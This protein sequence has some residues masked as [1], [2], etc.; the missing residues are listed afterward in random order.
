MRTDIH[1]ITGSHLPHPLHIRVHLPDLLDT[2]RR[3]AALAPL[4]LAIS[5]E[6]EILF[7]HHGQEHFFCGSLGNNELCDADC[8]AIFEGAFREST[9]DNRP[10]I[11]SCAAGLLFFA[12]PFRNDRDQHCCL[13]AGGVRDEAPELAL[14]E[15]L[16]NAPSGDGGTLLEKLLRRPQIKRAQMEEILGKTL[17]LLTILADEQT[18]AQPLRGLTQRLATVAGASA[19]LDRAQSSDAV[20]ELLGETLILLFDL[21]RVVI[22]SVEEEDFRLK[23]DLGPT[24]RATTCACERLRELLGAHP[25]GKPLLLRQEVG[26]FFPEIDSNRAICAPL[27]SEGLDLGLAVIFDV[28]LPGRDLLLLELLTGRAAAR[29]HR[30]R[31]SALHQERQASSRRL[32]AMLGELSLVETR[33]L[34]YQRIVAMSCELLRAARGSLMLLDETGE[35]LRI[36]AARG[37]NL[38]VAASIPLRLGEGIAGRVAKSGLH[39]LVTDIEKDSRVGIANRPRFQT[40][41]FI[42][43]PLKAQ[44]RI[45]GILNLADKETGT[46]FSDDDLGTL[47]QL[48]DHAALLI[49]RVAVYENARKLEELAARDP[50]TGLYNRRMLEARFQEELNRCSRLKHHF[51]IMMLDLDHFK[52]YNDQCGHIAG[53]HA[54]KKVSLLLKRSAR[55]M[56]IVTRYGGE[57]FCLLLPNTGKEEALFVAERIRR[58]IETEIFPGETALPTG[59]LTTS[60]GVACYP[61]DG[62]KFEPLVNAADIA[63]YQAKSKGR[64]R[65]AG[66]EVVPPALVK[67]TG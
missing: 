8:R 51:T 58:A 45:V 28:D 14:L 30:L 16:S 11:F 60:I 20:L 12:I 62:E 29:L 26:D 40:K 44:D 52:A 33:E 31:L 57:E 7:P 47:H 10:L 25:D 66:F 42:C 27:R 37:I 65:L 41:S 1:G 38:E 46:T 34:L 9:R 48:I 63:L 23:V 4:Q 6:Q 5:C 32:L 61:D 22:L 19:E 13:F 50:L 43:V 67:K 35:F 56:D 18:L 59:R 54:L 15:K 36:V 49:E 24:S 3:V 17:T 53:D 39:L 2:L 64:N 55:E 21:S